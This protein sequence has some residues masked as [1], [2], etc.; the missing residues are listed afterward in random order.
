MFKIKI[1]VQKSGKIYF[2]RKNSNVTEIFWRENS[3]ISKK[4]RGKKSRKKKEYFRRI[5]LLQKCFGA[6]IQIF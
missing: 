3:N 6:K 1:W 2:R 4:L 5:Y